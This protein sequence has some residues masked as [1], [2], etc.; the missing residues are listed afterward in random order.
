MPLNLTD[1]ATQLKIKQATVYLP[2]DDS[3]WNMTEL[4]ELEVFSSQIARVTEGTVSDELLTWGW[5]SQIAVPEGI[6]QLQNLKRLRIGG[7]YKEVIVSLPASISQ[8]VQLEELSIGPSTV[9]LPASL[10]A[11]TSLQSLVISGRG[12]L[13]PSWGQLASL[14][15]LR[16][17]S[18][19]Y[20]LYADESLYNEAGL[21]S[22]IDGDGYIHGPLP[23]EWGDL[24]NIE[25]LS[26]ATG[27]AGYLSGE[28]PSEWSRLSKLES[29]SFGNH[30]F[31]GHLPAEWGQ[32]T[33]L[34]YLNLSSNLLDGPIPPE[35]C[36]MI[37]LEYLYL[38][39]NAF[40]G[41][42]P[43]QISD[44][45]N[46]KILNLS[47]NQLTGS[48]VDFSN[49]RSLEYLSLGGN[50]LTGTINAR[51]FPMSIIGIGLAKNNL[52]LSGEFPNLKHLTKLRSFS[53]IVWS[54]G[55]ASDICSKLPQSLKESSNN[56]WS[57]GSIGYV[58]SEGS[59]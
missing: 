40:S 22:Y 36:Q 49:M 15:R 46:L 41:S 28:L 39:D 35:W 17:V 47:N 9:Q 8:L 11:L 58:Y 43:S 30:E 34:K 52:D 44:L 53:E 55:N 18:P 1:P 25:T 12:Q 33:Q 56:P 14:K 42:I 59:S 48:L 32:L 19:Q 4:E 2:V 24:S 29:I 6:G 23:A 38:E 5:E 51:Y 26:V 21:T 50:Q 57:C 13:P 10:S 27:Q 45:I 31:E 16:V 20:V 7:G 3:F 37:S 54:E